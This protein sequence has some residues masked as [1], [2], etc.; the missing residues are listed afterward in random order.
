VSTLLAAP[1]APSVEEPFAASRNHG[2]IPMSNATAGQRTKKILNIALAVTAIVV[3]FAYLGVNPF[4]VFGSL[5]MLGGYFVDNFIP[6]NFSRVGMHLGAV[7]D[8]LAFALVGTY[9][10]AIGSLTFGILMSHEIMPNKAVRVTARF[11]MTFLRNIPVIIWA[12]LL[13]FVFGIGNLIGLMA[14]IVATLGF[15][16]RSY[17]DSIDEIAGSKL[18]AL[19]ASGA[20][21]PQIIWHGLI[22][23]FVP[24]WINWT[25]F[26]F[27]INIRASAIL[28]M[29]GAGGIGILI[30][31]D[32]NLRNFPEV[33][34]LVIILLSLVLLTELTVNVAR[35][36]LNR[37][38]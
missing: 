25:L 1:E 15:L 21:L 11:I 30:Q 14:L 37:Q 2:N 26:S 22:P 10:S 18:E 9:I 4:Q 24:A 27:E 12:S 6:P 36:R 16:A 3:V 5:P 38:A 17:A 7:V 34:A 28:G 20:S 23:E 13:M 32:L 29:V 33:T 31:R 8:T 19:R 35:R